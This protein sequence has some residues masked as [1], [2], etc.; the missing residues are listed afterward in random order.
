M[1]VSFHL[2]ALHR[3]RF[4]FW[5]I[6]FSHIECLAKSLTNKKVIAPVLKQVLG[7]IFMVSVDK[8]A[9]PSL[10]VSR[11]DLL[12]RAA[13]IGTVGSGVAANGVWTYNN[14]L[15]Q[16]RS[17]AAVKDEL[18]DA[19]ES[20]KTFQTL[21]GDL[22]KK[23]DS[24]I[25]L[26][27]VVKAVKDVTP[28]TVRVE[29]EVEVMNFFTGTME[30]RPVTGSGVIIITSEGK[31]FI[32]TNGHVTQGSDI[33]RNGFKDSVYH[34]KVYNGSDTEKP[35]TFDA[36]PVLLENGE[37]AYSAPEEHD[38]ALLAIPPNAKIPDNVGIK[39]KDLSE[40]P[41]M[42]GDPLL[43]V[44]N[45][46][47]ESDSVSFG[48]ASHVDRKSSLN[49]NNHIQT[50]AA[51]NPGNSGGPL[52]RLRVENGNIVADLVGINTWAYRNAGGVGGAIR[53]DEIVKQ[54]NGW[55]IKP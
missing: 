6:L 9:A 31:R 48:I 27:Q 8:I 13:L 46:F 50:D 1:N 40:N 12:L 7:G 22:N 10:G 16:E 30:K 14:Q 28:S 53:L 42:V 45:P 20:N 34:I 19:R 23:L 29:G 44:G 35:I 4:F 32:L 17:I 5:T 37:R 51:I 25:S 41:V 18:H 36:A 55:G 33:K 21:L 24:K 11:R 15:E 49:K 2:Q 47:G 39:I 54:M 52:F 43:A 26:D 3:F 38:L